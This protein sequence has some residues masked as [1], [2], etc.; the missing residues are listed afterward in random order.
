MIYQVFYNCTIMILFLIGLFCLLLV[1]GAVLGHN[2][3]SFALSSA[4]VIGA[5]CFVG[6]I[7]LI[8]WA[9]LGSH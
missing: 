5:I 7:I 4:V 1:I 3:F 8:A 9:L 2:P 6:F